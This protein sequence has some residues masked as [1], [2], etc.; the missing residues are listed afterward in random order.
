ME[1]RTINTPISKNDL[2]QV[3]WINEERE[4]GRPKLIMGKVNGCSNYIS[5]GSIVNWQS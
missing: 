1:R 5:L 3:D 4:R 2:I